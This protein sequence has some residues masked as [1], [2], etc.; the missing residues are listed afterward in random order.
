MRQDQASCPVFHGILSLAI[1]PRAIFLSPHAELIKNRAG[2]LKTPLK[3]PIDVLQEREANLTEQLNLMEIQAQ[4]EETDLSEEKSP[5]RHAEAKKKEHK[6][7]VAVKPKTRVYG[8]V[9]D[10]NDG[11][12]T[13]IDVKV[14]NDPVVE[15]P[16]TV[17][18][19][20]PK[21]GNK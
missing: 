18:D 20:A 15:K 3:C 11:P 7:P 9:D 21:G 1:F 13:D 6:D 5:Y 12:I 4:H 8:V 10:T 17:L 14:N 19:M 2:T 16:T